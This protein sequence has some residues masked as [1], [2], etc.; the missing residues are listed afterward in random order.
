[1]SIW[2]KGFNII[3]GH[4]KIVITFE[5]IDSPDDNTK[6][7]N[8]IKT[9]DIKY[10]FFKGKCNN[11]KER[12]KIVKKKGKL[13]PTITKNTDKSFRTL[14]DYFFEDI[15]LFVVAEPADGWEQHYGEYI[16]LV[17]LKPGDRRNVTISLA[18]KNDYNGTSI[19]K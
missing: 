15:C 4:F 9:T 7:K 2:S 17:E 5:I 10:L 1:M 8:D 14:K 13:I 6:Y 3:T 11:E 16:K 12:R 19:K 18:P